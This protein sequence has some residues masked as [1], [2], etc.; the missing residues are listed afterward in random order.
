[1]PQ[2]LAAS[3]TLCLATAA[4]GG[5]VTFNAATPGDN[6]AARADLL[7]AVG[8]TTPEFLVDFE[9]GF[10]EGQNVH[11]ETGLFPGGLVFNDTGAGTPEAIITGL[12]SNLGG[13]NPVGSFSVSHDEGRFLEVNFTAGKAASYV[14]FL[15]ID[16]TAG[17]VV[18]T[19]EGGATESFSI[20]ATG[21]GGDSAEFFGI[22][23]ND[24]PAIRIV[25]V[26]I[27]GDGAWGLDNIE[28]GLVPEPGSLALV[29]LGG[30]GLLRRRR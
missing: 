28:W 20:D 19:Y 3:A 16:H 9:S 6:D 26:D 1:M 29:G 14:G 17:E 15:G 7:A 11:G 22:W 2:L 12:P 30:L 23:Q 5:G 8:V 4:H 21:A 24:M 27:G 10:T 25:S 13:S 18:V